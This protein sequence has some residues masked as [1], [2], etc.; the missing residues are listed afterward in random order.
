LL[1]S[2][3]ALATKQATAVVPIVIALAGDPVGAGLIPF[4]V[5]E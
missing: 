1:R 5:I 4:R 3:A 2:E